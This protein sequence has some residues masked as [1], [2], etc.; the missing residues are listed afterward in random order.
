M[1]TSTTAPVEKPQN[2]VAG[3]KHWRHDLVAGLL[4]SLISLPFSLGIAVASGAP[5]VAGLTSAIIAGLVLPFLGGSYVTISGPAAGLAP[6]LL[7]GMTLLG[8]GSDPAHLAVG[9]PLLLGVICMTGCVQIVLARLKAARYCALFPTTVVEGMLASIGL[10]IIVKQLPL[11]IGHPFKAHD[12]FPMVAE[13]PSQLAQ[14]NPRVFT[15]GVACLVL[16]FALGASKARWLKVIP[17]PLVVVL[18]GLVLGRL[19]GL[20]GQYL[21]KVPDQVLKH[22][23]VF[24]NFRGLFSDPT[25][26]WAIIGTVLTLT[27]I[28]G[29]E[30]LATIKAIDKIDPFR[31]KSDPDRTLFAM[32]VSNI[33]SSVAGGLT[34]IPGGVK[35]TANIVGGG[36]TQWANFYNACFLL[37]FLLAGKGLINLI[38]LGAVGAVVIYTGFKLCAP[39]VWRHIAHIGSE[40]L[41]LFAMT[42]LVTLCTD[43]LW[44]IFFGMGV[45]LIMAASFSWSAVRGGPGR[46]PVG[47]ALARRLGQVAELFGNPVMKTAT[48][49]DGYHVYFGRPMV[50]FNSLH[51]SRALEQA[52]RGAGAVYL[53]VTDL[54]TLI[55]HT[56]SDLL[57]YFVEERER[58]GEGRVRILGLERMRMRSR[59]ASC[60]RVAAPVLAPEREAAL[61]ALARVSL[62]AVAPEADP[63]TLL[64]RLS[65]THIAGPAA[66]PGAHPVAAGAA[67]AIGSLY[68]GAAA[69]LA[70][71]G[72]GLRFLLLEGDDRRDLG[73]LSL[74]RVEE[75]VLGYDGGLTHFSL[76]RSPA[77]NA[78]PVRAQVTWPDRAWI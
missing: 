16:V 17:P 10:L 59:D 14:L 78:E 67:R 58:S 52:P 54:V 29:V 46:E 44:G 64:E 77:P 24:P 9:Y 3:L 50:C 20:E 36:R 45:K 27:M 69:L 32:G 23:I 72:Q 55:D 28:D 49:G 34:I 43:L 53:H 11:L 18:F 1:D 30:S 6:A 37:L 76:H 21:I 56:M 47:R 26:V 65:L 42:I 4:V 38:P 62:T 19:L 39:R 22:G 8:K 63:V 70:R 73:R 41:A 66:D 68:A 13:V 60:M 71:L 7:A 48:A 40:Q 5:P 61:Q 35:S 57:Q 31:R 75:D 2:G 51:V 15:L 12:F 25:L 74:T 33:C